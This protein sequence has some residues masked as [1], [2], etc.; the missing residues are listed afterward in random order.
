MNQIERHTLQEYLTTKLQGISLDD[1]C[2]IFINEFDAVEQFYNLSKGKKTGNMISLLF[3]P[4][5]LDTTTITSKISIFESLK[6]ENLM[7][8]LARLFLYNLS[9]GIGNSFFNSIQRGYNGIQY[10]NEFP[11]FVARDIIKNYS[12]KNKGNIKVLDPCAGWGGR[13]IGAA[14]L[15]NVI[16][17]ACEPSS[18]TFEGLNK[19]G[20]WLKQFSNNFEYKIYNIPYEDLKNDAKYDIALTSP[21]YFDTEHYSKEKNN[22]MNRYKTFDEWVE[23]FYNP[24]IKNTVERIKEDGNFILNVGSRKY[25]LKDKLM[26]ICKNEHYHCE[27]INR[28]YLSGNGEGRERFFQISKTPIKSKQSLF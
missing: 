6:H 1:F 11:P 10:V 19:L 23:L 16:Y 7:S 15:N 3:N 28:S 22:S 4:H 12:N 14:S 9:K 5:R 18:K 13:M 20:E 17:I 24:L 27:E 2:R 8:G 25:P 26:E 21:P